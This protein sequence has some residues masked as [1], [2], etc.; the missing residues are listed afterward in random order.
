MGNNKKNKKV[1][2]KIIKD[3]E[4]KNEKNK[5]SNKKYKNKNE[6][7]IVFRKIKSFFSSKFNLVLFILLIVLGIFAFIQTSTNQGN[8]SEDDLDKVVI[9]YFFSP[10]CHFC[11]QQKPIM[12]EIRDERTDVVLYEHDI[13]TKKGSDLFYKMARDAGLDLS[14]LAVPAIFINKDALIGLQTKEKIISA[15]DNC[16][17]Q[18]KGDEYKTDEKET[19]QQSLEDYEL[20]FFGKVDLTKWSLPVLTVILGL[21]DG[22]NPCALWVLIFLITMLMGEKS[23]KKIWL[24]VGS[25]VLASAVSYFLFMTAWLNLFLVMGYI[26]IVT[27]IIGLFAVGSGILHIK[28]W[29]TTKGDLTCE[30]GDEKSHEK[31]MNKIQRIIAQPITIGIIF[32]VIGLAFAVNAIEFVCSAAIPAVYTQLL[33]LS[34]ISTLQHYLYI[35]LYVFFYMLDHIII[36][37]MAAFALGSGFTQKYA[38]HCKL[39][40]GIVMTIIGLILLFAPHL[41]R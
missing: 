21:I 33:A 30:V 36:F 6:S 14:R 27:L 16:V 1:S 17:D 34:G 32:S 11:A 3:N 31:T 25:F 5:L 19:T 29:I 40:G 22:F 38:K 13:S 8:I 2:N 26:G 23:K 7:N 28:T 35:L 41:L 20:P 37:S 12:Y 9:N 4:N 39:I 15:I 10:T 18:C 24:V